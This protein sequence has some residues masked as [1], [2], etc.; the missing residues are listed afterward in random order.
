MVVAALVLLLVLLPPFTFPRTSTAAESPDAV[1]PRHTLQDPAPARLGSVGG[2]QDGDVPALVEPLE[3]AVQH[4]HGERLPPRRRGRVVRVEEGGVL[5]PRHLLP[6]AGPD[7]E[8]VAL[9]TAPAQ[10]RLQLHGD[11]RLAAGR[12]A[13]EDEEEARSCGRGA[14]GRGSRGGPPVR[15]RGR[16]RNK[17]RCRRPIH[18]AREEKRGKKRKPV[19]SVSSSACERPYTSDRTF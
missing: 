8:R 14:R 10:E 2:V 5:R 3:G 11:R 16:R 6:P 1:P 19:F 18:C 7:V 12:K 9:L 15:V 17:S 13:D 4:G